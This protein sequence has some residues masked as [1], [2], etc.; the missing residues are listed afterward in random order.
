MR[1]RRY[2][3]AESLEKLYSDAFAGRFDSLLHAGD[4]AYDFDTARG[5]VGD[6]YMRQ[7]EPVISSIPYNGI[8]GNHERWVMAD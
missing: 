4:Y 1:P 3:N 5:S 8:P 6:G 7:L 2:F